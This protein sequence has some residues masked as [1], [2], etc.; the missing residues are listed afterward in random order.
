MDWRHIEDLLAAA[1]DVYSELKNICVWNKTNAGMGSF[2]RSKHEFICVFKNGSAAHIN[3]IELGRHGR[4]RTNI[5]DHAGVNT[6]GAERNAELAMHPTVK[7]VA[8]VADAILDCSRR[9]D[10]ILDTFAGSGTTIIAAE[11][12]GRRA[13][14][15]ELDPAYVET[16]IRRWQDYTGETATH[17]IT[18]LTLEDLREQRAPATDTHHV[19]EPEPDTTGQGEQP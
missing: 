5:W 9:G 3:N 1:R 16:A 18:G 8:M 14:V 7:P 15:M 19:P 10:I 6:F 4:Y 13:Y 12:T 11:R 2:Y 17:A